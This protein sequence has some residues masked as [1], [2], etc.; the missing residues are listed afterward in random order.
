MLTAFIP[1]FAS[2]ASSLVTGAITREI[3]LHADTA[4]AVYSDANKAKLLKLATAEA[5]QALDIKLLKG[6]NKLEAKA[7]SKTDESKLD[8]FFK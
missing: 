5:V 2:Q 4:E 8:K 3:K 1:T 6:V 7:L